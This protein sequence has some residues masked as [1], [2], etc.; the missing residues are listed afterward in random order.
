[1]QQ[2]FVMNSAFMHSLGV[3]LAD[4]VRGDETYELKVRHLYRRILSRDPSVEELA[5]GRRYLTQGTVERFAEI[6]LSTNEE[7]FWP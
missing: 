2:L 4:A 1:M 7:I 3:A 6:L 5:E